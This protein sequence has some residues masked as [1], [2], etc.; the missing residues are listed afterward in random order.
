MC[1]YIYIYIYICKYVLVPPRANP[2]QTSPP[3]LW[4][5]K[6]LEL[7]ATNSLTTTTTTTNDDDIMII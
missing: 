2:S 6:P 7:G 4:F 5:Q 1:V 3:T